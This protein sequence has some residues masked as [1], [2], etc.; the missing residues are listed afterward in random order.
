MP[1]DPATAINL[2]AI[3]ERLPRPDGPRRT[4]R[5]LEHDMGGPVFEVLARN[6]AEDWPEEPGGCDGVYVV[7]SGEGAFRCGGEVLECAVGDVLFAPA[8]APRRFERLSRGFSTW[9]ILL[10]RAAAGGDRGGHV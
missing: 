5:V 9:R 10:G 4:V 6:G 2:T 3:A 1:L 8:G 7:I